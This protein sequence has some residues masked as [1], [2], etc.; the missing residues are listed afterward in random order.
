MKR[1]RPSP[2]DHF[3]SDFESVG[4]QSLPDEHLC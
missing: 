4:H 3:S 2:R 1:A